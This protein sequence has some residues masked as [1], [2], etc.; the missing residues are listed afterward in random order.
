MLQMCD[1]AIFNTK[2]QVSSYSCASG[3]KEK[4]QRNINESFISYIGT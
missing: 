4:E 1:S 2:P 3:H